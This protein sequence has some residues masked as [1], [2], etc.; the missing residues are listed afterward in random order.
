MANVRFKNLLCGVLATGLT[1]AYGGPGFPEDCEFEKKFDIEEGCC[2]TPEEGF[3]GGTYYD[4][5][6]KGERIKEQIE[7]LNSFVSLLIDNSQDLDPEFSATVNKHF[8]D[9]V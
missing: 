1:L 3:A 2:Y 7:I 5:I 4:L 6:F 8:W 9:M